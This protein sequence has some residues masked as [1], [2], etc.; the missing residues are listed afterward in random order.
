[1]IWPLA[2]LINNVQ[3]KRVSQ[4]RLGL[5]LGTVGVQIINN[6]YDLRSLAPNA[7]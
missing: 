2:P 4:F 1:M 7:Q 6:Y 5:G 3:F